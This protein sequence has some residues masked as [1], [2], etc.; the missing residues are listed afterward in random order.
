M[1]VHFKLI[2]FKNFLSSGNVFTEIPLDKERTTLISG[3]N[4]SGK[5]TMIDAI[6]FALYGKPQRKINKPQL[7]NSI[8]QKDCLVEI[9][10]AV[11]GNDY[12]VRRGLK[13]TVFEI[14]KNG[15]VLDKNA[16]AP[17]HQIYLE[18]NIL[19]LNYKSFGQIVVLGSATYV[20]F[21]ELPTG[22]RR[23]IIED[24]LDIQIFT[25]M[26]LLLKERVN[27]NKS[28][29]VDLNH[30]VDLAKTHI[31]SAEEN[32]ESIKKI[33]MLEVGKI[34]EKVKD[35]LVKIEENTKI[36]SDLEEQIDEL[37]KTIGDKASM[38][39]KKEKLKEISYDLE[40]KKS[41]FEKDLSFYHDNDNCPVCKQGIEHDFKETVVNEKTSKRDEI[42]AAT[43]ELKKKSDEI[44]TRLSEI[45]DVEDA[46]HKLHLKA[47]EHRGDVK[48]SKSALMQYKGELQ[49]A[50]KD[51]ETVD[52]S[53]VE[54][55]KKELAT[56]QTELED[57]FDEKETLSVA[58]SML[59]D[60]G[61]KTRIVKQYI[62]VMNTLINK[63]LSE[64]ELFVDFHLDENFNEV[65]KSRFRDTFS[66]SSF[67]EGEK[68]RINL[69]ILFAW[70]TVSKMRNSISTNLLILDETLDGASD[71]EAVES[72]VKILNQQDSKE[73]TFVI[74]HRGESF[75][76]MFGDHI[77]FK[78]VRNF[79]VVD[80]D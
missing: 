32:S 51:V 69:S 38:R 12:M 78:K 24:L 61:I 37:A 8:N 65:I 31:K 39:S 22:S 48:S 71:S 41:A 29:I 15:N 25:T 2:R 50:Q 14:W 57:L 5:S 80:T 77:K 55:Y 68:M 75:G 9:E 59:K 33:K 70:R 64:F 23:E 26:N 36:I 13:P 44:E 4:G 10:F 34:K 52:V 53:K 49:E 72:L 17:D 73:N 54:Q 40:S 42:V 58:G 60:G 35:H 79:S 19:N 66:Y 1:N 27:G 43:T 63:Y 3:K 18:Q 7:L 62:P 45:S 11:G 6:T 67:S 30:S 74:S 20:P 28:E 56:I 46:I 21:M 76:E 16:K 47:G